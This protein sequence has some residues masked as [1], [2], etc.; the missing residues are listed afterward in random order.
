MTVLEK[1]HV[2]N[3]KRINVFRLALFSVKNQKFDT[4]K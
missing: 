1:K 4:M 3:R 2:L